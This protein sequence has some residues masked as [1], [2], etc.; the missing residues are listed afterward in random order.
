MEDHLRA[1]VDLE[2]ELDKALTPARALALARYAIG[3]PKTLSREFAKAGKPRWRHLLRAG[4]GLFAASWVLPAVGDATGHLRG[5]EA[6][7]LA[8]EWGNPG[9][10]HGEHGVERCTRRQGARHPGRTLLFAKGAQLSGYR[11]PDHPPPVQQRAIGTVHLPVR[12]ADTRSRRT[13][14]VGQSVEGG[15]TRAPS[16]R[17]RSRW[18]ER[19]AS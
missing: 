13:G 18:R 12:V 8:L 17:P 15:P 6:F 10:L 11:A 7:Q 5:W 16:P 2:L 9:V 3:E 4:G 14:S 1:H 19:R